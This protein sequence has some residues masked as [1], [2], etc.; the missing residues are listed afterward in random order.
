MG[1]T[2]S[3]AGAVRTSWR[4]SSGFVGVLLVGI[5]V[6]APPSSS[7]QRRV[8]LV[9]GNAAYEEAGATLVNSVNDARAVAEVLDELDFDVLLRTDL[10]DDGMADAVFDFSRELSFGDVGVFYY[11]GHAVELNDGR[12][13]LVPVDLVP[14]RNVGPEIRAVY[15]R[16]RSLR[17]DDVLEY[18]GAAGT[19]TRI[20]VLDA[21][22]DNPFERTG[23]LTR[24]GLGLM[25]PRGGLVAYAAQPGRSAA[26][27]SR[28]AQHLVAALRIPGL[29]A[30]EV[31]TRVSEAV[32][33]A[34][35]G[36]QL[37]MQQTSGAVGRFVFRPEIVE[38]RLAVSA[39]PV[40]RDSVWRNEVTIAGPI[41]EAEGAEPLIISL[42]PYPPDPRSPVGRSGR[43]LPVMV[44]GG[45][46]NPWPEQHADFHGHIEFYRD[47]TLLY[48]IDG[49]SV[50]WVGIA[51]VTFSPRRKVLS[52]YVS[53]NVGGASSGDELTIVHHGL[54]EGWIEVEPY[55]ENAQADRHMTCSEA[56]RPW[57]SR[58]GD[59]PTSSTIWFEPCRP[60][61][62]LR[63]RE[64]F[65]SRMRFLGGDVLD[66]DLEDETR[67]DCRS[68][69]T[70]PSGL[71]SNLL[72]AS[73][74]EFDRVESSRFEVV[75]LEHWGVALSESFG[76]ILARRKLPGAPWTA[77]YGNTPASAARCCYS[78]VSVLGFQSEDEIHVSGAV[79]GGR[80]T[81]DA[82]V[83]L[84]RM[85]VRVWGQ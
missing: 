65:A 84:D 1:S 53:S 36:G 71:V 73:G 46:S 68:C 26:E 27:D 25:A 82:V 39:A 66:I 83:D 75:I 6:A 80:G 15:I 29:S 78:P 60:R 22:R 5:L 24:G 61:D 7:A 58:F 13:Y 16:N 44:V 55:G 31:F 33:A 18:M 42:V 85:T 28:Y 12:N 37:P 52:V 45:D 49:E 48:T 56:Q 63:R 35:G 59:R 17:A 34:S 19:G 74:L 9:I 57:V 11:A 70:I 81:C 43:N 30:S 79:C 14:P 38:T 67:L 51:G 41:F 4:G 40:L 69:D 8:A 3:T 10:D 50:A 32:E 21:G 47:A 72:P 76:L 54:E 77:V 2:F 62:D 23:G 20:M 64:R